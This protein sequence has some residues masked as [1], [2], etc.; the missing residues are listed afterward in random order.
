[1]AKQTV[2]AAAYKKAA[3]AADGR[4]PNSWDYDL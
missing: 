1:M 2:I 4:I 3:P